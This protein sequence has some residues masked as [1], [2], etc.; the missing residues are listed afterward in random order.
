MLQRVAFLSGAEADGASLGAYWVKVMRLFEQVPSAQWVVGV[1]SV[2]V[3]VVP[4]KH[5]TAVSEQRW[6]VG[7][8]PCLHAHLDF[9]A[10]L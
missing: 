4:S 5:P 8:L 1:A 3:Q 2:A 7:W 10:I 6:S 9:A